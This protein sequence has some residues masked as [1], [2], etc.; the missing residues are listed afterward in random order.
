MLTGI[1]ERR[2]NES[3]AIS[4]S[5]KVKNF[6][7]VVRY[8]PTD[9]RRS[10][11]TKQDKTHTYKTIYSYVIDRWLKIKETEKILKNRRGKG[12]LSCPSGKQQ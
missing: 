4:E 1:Q 3:E 8:Q 2:E 6:S 9:S 10:M 12:P 11:N 7:N 5:V